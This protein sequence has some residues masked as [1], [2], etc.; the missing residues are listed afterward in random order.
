MAPEDPLTARAQ[1]RVGATILGKYVLERVLGVGGMASVYVALHRNN[2]RFALKMLHPEL[3]LRQD[4]RARFLREGYAANTVGHAGAVAVMDDDVAEDGSAFLV[5]ELLEG[6]PV[7]ALWLRSGHHLSTRHVLGIAY[8]TLDVLAAAH[9]KEIIHRDIKP[10]NL[11]LTSSGHVKV[12]DFGIARLLDPGSSASTTRSGTAIGTPA[13]MA[14]EQALAKP[15]TVDAASDVFS[16]GATMFTLL[17]GRYV[18]EG[19]SASELMVHTAT[20]PAPSLAAVRPDLPREVVALV[21]R[22]LAFHKGDRWPSAAAMRDAIATTYRGLFGEGLSLSSLGA[23]VSALDLERTVHSSPVLPSSTTNAE[24]TARPTAPELTRPRGRGRRAGVL[25]GVAAALL[26][27]AGSFAFWRTHARHEPPVVAPAATAAPAPAPGCKTNRDC[28]SGNP[29]APRI[30]REGSCRELASV[31]CHVIANQQ[32]LEDDATLWIGT[33]FPTSEEGDGEDI[34]AN[35]RA[36]ELASHDFWDVTHGLPSATGIGAARPIGIVACDDAKHPKEAARHLVDDVGVPAVIGFSLPDEIADLSTNLFLPRGV[37]TFDA[38]CPDEFIS[39]I[40]QPAGGPRLLW[41]T[42][43]SGRFGQLAASALVEGVIEPEL[44]AT[45]AIGKDGRIRVAE[46]RVGARSDTIFDNLHFNGKTVAENRDDFLY[47]AVWADDW[48]KGDFKATVASL[49]KFRPDVVIFDDVK[50]LAA[51]LDPVEAHHRAGA[52]P[53]WINIGDLLSD[54]IKHG[55]SGRPG[56]ARRFYEFEV[57]R[58]AN[59]ERLHS[60]MRNAFPEASTEDYGEATYDA[61]YTIAYAAYAA[62]PGRDPLT[63]ATIARGIARLLPPGTPTDVGRAAKFQA[64][65]VLRSGGSIDLQGAATELDFDPKT[66]NSTVDLDVLC[67]APKNDTVSELPS[68]LRFYG[69]TSRLEGEE[70]CK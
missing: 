54:P 53:R 23:A 1:G 7:D 45:P 16:V 24:G 14:P 35:E 42:T 63:G 29:D 26:V 17:S 48:F 70:Q 3:S 58:N 36:A 15:G 43:A 30:C 68:G 62:S 49:V 64:F 52:A 12:L 31:D 38:M 50:L 4:I 37:L 34:K 33:M 28:P 6:E 60:A 65:N 10:A 55:L 44:R 56:L 8:Q 19:E 25:P 67:V 11:F 47:I 46:V 21:D 40:P 22:A 20:R 39:A 66:G 32:T 27:A 2:K 41:L 51:I 18:H 13:F 57:V 5:M 69:R 9:A 61:V 59:R